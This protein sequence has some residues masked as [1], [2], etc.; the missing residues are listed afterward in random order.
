[1]RAEP[2]TDG[3]ILCGYCKKCTFTKQFSP[4]F[5]PS[6]AQ[7]SL[8]AH[9]Q[10]TVTGQ[11][12][13]T[14][15]RLAIWSRIFPWFWVCCLPLSFCSHNSP[16]FST[17]ACVYI[18]E[19]LLFFEIFKQFKPA[20]F[21]GKGSNAFLEGWFNALCD[22]LNFL[23]ERQCNFIPGV[24]ETVMLKIDDIRLNCFFNIF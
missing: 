15:S 2:A 7:A 11:L 9:P 13:P 10:W 19:N 22:E 1:M 12:V 14:E 17:F 8:S 23:S 21:K 16:S 18:G 4:S 3:I 5:T 6:Y 24:L 20:L